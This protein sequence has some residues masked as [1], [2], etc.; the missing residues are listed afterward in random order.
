MSHL[1]ACGECQAAKAQ[2]QRVIDAGRYGGAGGGAS[3][4]RARRLGAS[5]TRSLTRNSAQ[6]LAHALLVPAVGAGRR[7]CRP[8]PRRVRGRPLLRWRR[9]RARPTT[10]PWSPTLR[11]R[12]RAAHRSGRSPRS[13]A[14]DAGRT[15][16]TTDVDQGDVLA[17][18]QARAA[19]LVAAN[20]LIRQSAIAVRRHRRRRH[21][22]GSRARVAGD[23]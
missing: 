20:R 14:D 7:R 11:T 16:R 19:D 21:S 22:R 9:G 12:A 3:R 8:R 5:R 13:H 23:C 18:E 6:R 1:A 2:L 17:G 10:R 15:G 4:L